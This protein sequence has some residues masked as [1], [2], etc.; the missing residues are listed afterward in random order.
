MQIPYVIDLDDH[1]ASGIRTFIRYHANG[2]REEE[3][4]G[5]LDGEGPH[6]LYNVTDTVMCKMPT[7]VTCEEA[8][9]M[10][11]EHSFGYETFFVDSGKMYLY[12]DGKRCL[13]Q[14]GD[15]VHLQA[16]QMHSMA[17]LE[18]VKW[19]G[20]FHDLDSFADAVQVNT[21]TA[22][23]PGAAEDPA[24]Q[25]A[26]GPRDF[27]RHEQPAYRDVPAE[28]MGAV[29]HPSRPL[30]AYAIGGL[31]V[32]VIIPRWENAGVSEVVMAELPAGCAVT[33]GYHQTREQY[34]VRSGRVKL[35]I[36]GEEYIAG[37][38]CIINVPKLAP[39][40]LTALE[41]AEVY[42]M[43][44]QTH[45]FSFLQDYESLRTFTPARLQE[46]ETLPVLKEKYRV[47]VQSIVLA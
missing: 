3:M 40:T 17:S 28:E 31:T 21:V 11:H 13:I 5:V 37:K 4:S 18:D 12:A 2:E 46:P 41:P 24:F 42:D 19:R 26:K 39:F 23:I 35:S 7:G 32:K 33:W 15:I 14:T 29:R 47:E 30:A 43:G 1:E 10:A 45:W 36:L 38:A 25:K 20:F 6:G 8:S 27:I 34:Y 16:G 44:G 9:R 22:Q